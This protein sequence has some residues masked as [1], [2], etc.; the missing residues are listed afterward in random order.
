MKLVIVTDERGQQF[1]LKNLFTDRGFDVVVV[2]SE[3]DFMTHT[4]SSDTVGIVLCRAVINGMGLPLD[5]VE[6]VSEF[7]IPLAVLGCNSATFAMWDRVGVTM[8]FDS[9]LLMQSAAREHAT[10]VR[11]CEEWINSHRKQ[12]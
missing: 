9:E 6:Y 3:A 7:D 2:A 11:R 1:K 5:L 10:E 4:K 12:T 8:N